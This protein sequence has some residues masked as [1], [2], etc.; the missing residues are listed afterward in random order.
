[1]TFRKLSRKLCV[2]TLTLAFLLPTTTTLAA[3]I[4]FDDD[5]VD[6]GTITFDTNTGGT[7]SGSGI[8]ID[9]VRA[10]STALN[11]TNCS[12][13]FETGPL[14]SA[15]G[16]FYTYGGGGSILI[17]GGTSGGLNLPN[18]TLLTGSFSDTSNFVVSTDSFTTSGGTGSD[19]KN[20][21]LIAY[22]GETGPF[23]F[24]FST[25]SF[26]KPTE[27]NPGVFQATVSEVDLINTPVPNPVPVP[28][29]VLLMGTGLMG[30]ILFRRL[31]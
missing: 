13:S 6:G 25:L 22:F 21:D 17:E 24:S 4:H 31:K 3:I 18:T 28:S 23:G 19:T 15:A 16:G 29:A 10:D 1:M 11:C 27:I 7:F 26:G 9:R 8:A 30:L 14:L 12:L 20:P 5:L 2:A